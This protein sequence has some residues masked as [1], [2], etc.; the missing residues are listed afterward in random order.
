MLQGSALSMVGLDA[1]VASTLGATEAFSPGLVAR[2]Y[3]SG[4]SAAA[5]NHSAFRCSAACFGCGDNSNNKT[6]W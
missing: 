5:L 1:R 3:A 4:I 6:V 2:A